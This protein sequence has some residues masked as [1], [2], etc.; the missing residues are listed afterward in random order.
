VAALADKD[1]AVITANAGGVIASANR[2][3][4][5]LLGA[6]A[7][8]NWFLHAPPCMLQQTYHNTPE[9]IIL[10]NLSTPCLFTAITQK[11]KATAKASSRAGTSAC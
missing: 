6:L 3:A 2:A 9:L 5:R 4:E 10:Y 8:C 1:A 7:A 11:Q